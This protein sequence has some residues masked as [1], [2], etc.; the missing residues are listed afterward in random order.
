MLFGSLAETAQNRLQFACYA[1]FQTSEALGECIIHV[2][3]FHLPSKKRK[4]PDVY[5]I[6]ESKTPRKVPILI[7]QYLNGTQSYILFLRPA[8]T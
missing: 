3:P 4:Y 8:L 7:Q 6:I 2:F 5:I 1:R